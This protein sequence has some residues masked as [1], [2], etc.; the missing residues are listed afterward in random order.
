[1]PHSHK[2]FIVITSIFSPTPSIKKFAALKD[3]QLI[4][5]GDKKSPSDWRCPGVIYLDP[6]EQNKLGFSILDHLPWNHYC[7]KMLGYLYAIKEGADIIYDTDDDNSPKESWP[8][9]P[10]LSGNFKT[11][12]G[13]KFVNIYNYYSDEYIWPRGYPLDRIRYP[14]EPVESESEHEVS[15]WQ[16][17]AD[18]DPDVDAIYRLTID[19]QIHFKNEPPVVLDAGTVCPINSQNT[20]FKKE[21]FPL[22]YLPAFVTFRFTD[23]L[24]GLVAQ[25]VLW[26]HG[27]RLGFGSANLVQE[28]NPHDLMRD[29]KQEVPVFL[30]S[31]EVIDIANEAL[32]HSSVGSMPDQLYSIYE[33]LYDKGIVQD[34]EIGLLKLWLNDLKAVHGI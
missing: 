16:F 13:Q 8:S 26:Q 12:S 33:A 31:E 1:M 28:R 7:R 17:L 19:K 20:L 10:Q 9:L 2:K 22:L 25:P 21:V 29:F 3:W 4:V 6:D 34:E 23:I 18:E 24:R 5:V 30:H 11:L 27:L 15:I 14:E 32:K